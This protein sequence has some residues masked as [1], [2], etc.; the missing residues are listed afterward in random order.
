MNKSY[1]SKVLSWFKTSQSSKGK[2]FGSKSAAL[3]RARGKADYH[4][5]DFGVRKLGLIKNGKSKSG[6]C[7]ACK[8]NQYSSNPKSPPLH[9]NCKC[10]FT[11]KGSKQ[12][13]RSDF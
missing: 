8:A 9:P 10:G 4:D 7:K 6:E 1:K 12:I 13:T 11:N 5:D 2:D 3:N